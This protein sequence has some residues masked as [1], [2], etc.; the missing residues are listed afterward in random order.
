M[1]YETW[2][3]LGYMVI[4]GRMYQVPP[5]YPVPALTNLFIPACN[6]FEFYVMQGKDRAMELDK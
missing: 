4:K 2:Y 6:L 5:R 1:D 3:Q